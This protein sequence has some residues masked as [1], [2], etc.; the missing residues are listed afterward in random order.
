MRR[1]AAHYIY[2]RQVYRMHYLE[3]DDDGRLLG[4]YPL[5]EEIAGTAFYD[6][7]LIPLPSEVMPEY[8]F[9]WK[10]WPTLTETVVPG[11]RVD[12]FRLRG[13]PLATAKLGT[14]DSRCNGYIE[15]L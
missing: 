9:V 4:I 8:P 14:Y 3:L 5:T 12:L 6:G 1:I 13:I 2:C 11:T 15:R 10:E 7:V